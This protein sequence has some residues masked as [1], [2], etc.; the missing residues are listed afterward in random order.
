MNHQE[1]GGLHMST[2]VD[3]DT[4]HRYI[5]LNETSVRRGMIRTRSTSNFAAPKKNCLIAVTLI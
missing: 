2:T 3:S 5:W 4:A 1:T